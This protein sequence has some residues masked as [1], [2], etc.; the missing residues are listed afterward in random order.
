MLVG[1]PGHSVRTVRTAGSAH[2][3]CC[4]LPPLLQLFGSTSQ[5]VCP[6]MHL[7]AA[8][9]SVRCLMEPPAGRAHACRAT[10]TKRAGC[11]AGAPNIRDHCHRPG[12]HQSLRLHL[13]EP[14]LGCY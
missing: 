14:C 9:R 8:L 13:Q 5:P 4:A 10:R 1:R 6:V 3:S 7:H 11:C 12:P 2:A